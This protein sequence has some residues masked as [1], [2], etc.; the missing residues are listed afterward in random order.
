M[1]GRQVVGDQKQSALAGQHESIEDIGASEANEFLEFFGKIV[2][3]HDRRDGDIGFRPDDRPHGFV[4]LLGEHLSRN[5]LQ[6]ELPILVANRAPP[7]LGMA[8]KLVT[9][10]T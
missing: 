1:A 3:R 2:A 9:A 4:L 10:F 6:C 8:R 5:L 7:I